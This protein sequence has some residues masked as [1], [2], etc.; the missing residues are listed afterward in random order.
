MGQALGQASGQ[1]LFPAQVDV[2]AYPP[3]RLVGLFPISAISRL[4]ADAETATL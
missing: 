1:A 4:R 2:A 3:G